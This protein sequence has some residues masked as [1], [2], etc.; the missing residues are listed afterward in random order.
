MQTLVELQR[1]GDA[2]SEAVTILRQVMTVERRALHA[3]AVKE[4]DRGR[5]ARVRRTLLAKESAGGV[6]TPG[7]A[8]RREIAAARRVVRRAERLRAAMDSAA[9]IYLPDR[10]HAVR[11]AVKKLRYALEVARQMGTFRATRS[12]SSSKSVR[13]VSR[14]L[15]V[16]KRTQDLLGR[17][18]DFEVLIARTRAVQTS[19]RSPDLRLQGELDQL[20]R[21]LETECR[22][23]HAHYMASRGQLVE[24]C[25]RIE[26][27]AA[28][29]A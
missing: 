23:L 19:P 20:V 6:G 8:T 25:D 28:R 12:R 22:L 26:A 9:G 24:M 1:A 29:A 7:A 5:F 10:L 2:P 18:H 11:I 27:M 16:L 15:A 17:M 4:I 14:Q 3:E 13:S 21:W